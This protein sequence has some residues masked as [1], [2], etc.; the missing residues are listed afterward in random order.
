MFVTDR[1]RVAAV[2][3]S[4]AKV[5]LQR[6]EGD[7][8]WALPGGQIEADE[9]S[10]Q[11]LAREL[12]EELGEEFSIGALLWSVDQVFEQNGTTFAERGLYYSAVPRDSGF[13]RRSGPFSGAEQQRRL[14]F[15]WFDLA[16]LEQL[17][18]RPHVM[19]DRLA[20]IVRPL[21]D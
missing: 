11:A 12:S 5:L 14:V 1:Q 4:G 20:D 9:T 17:D 19:R 10:D 7:E 8:F 15:D 16:R 21:G 3:V 6:A 13:L 2:V 18:C